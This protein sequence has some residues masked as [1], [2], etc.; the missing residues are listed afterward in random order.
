MKNRVLAFIKQHRMIEPGDVVCAAC[1]G[2]A[3]SVCLLVMLDELRREGALS[4]ELT[5]CHLNHQ[6]RGAASDADQ[7]YV[8]QLCRE[9]GIP[10]YSCSENITERVRKSM[11][12]GGAALSDAERPEDFSGHQ[13][14]GLEA[15]GRA[16]REDLYR[17]CVE[18][19]G[20]D[21]IALAHHADDQAETVLMH[22]ARGAGLAGMAGIHPVRGRKIRPLLCLRRSEIEAWLTSRGIAWCED[23]T[24]AEDDYTRNRVRHHI[25]PMVEQFVH[26]EAAKHIAE[27]A[28]VIRLADEWIREEAKKRAA[29]LVT[30]PEPD[31]EADIKTDSLLPHGRTGRLMVSEALL[32]E[33]EIMQRYILM[34]VL[35]KTAGTG[36]DFGRIHLQIMQD[37]LKGGV[38]RSADLPRGI[39]AVRTYEGLQVFGEIQGDPVR[40]PEDCGEIQGD[41]VRKPEDCS[42]T[43]K[44]IGFTAEEQVICWGKYRFRCRFTDAVPEPIPEKAYTKWINCDMMNDNI[45]IRSRKSGDYLVLDK[46]G[47]R[48]SLKAWMINHKI[49]VE[50]RDQIPVLSCG[51]EVLWIIGGRISA[52]A[53]IDSGTKRILEIECE[54]Q[55][56]DDFERRRD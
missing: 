28:E 11:Q 29:L 54:M 15:A 34:Y 35:E 40:K 45:A 3:D 44:K 26:P 2:G 23:H 4:F 38:S 47:G 25:L 14:A 42:E 12:N 41:S 48:Q 46:D 8:A 17:T 52:S 39:R 18:M 50:M 49:P 24:N 32:G 55:A 30:G 36:L 43:V 5:A 10:L 53:R 16:A 51:H 56:E 7:A 31:A 13:A 1:S 9:R 21:R 19:H 6:L 37:L 33:P 27:S 22:M 20:A